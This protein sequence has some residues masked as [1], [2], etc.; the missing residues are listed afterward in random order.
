[1]GVCVFLNT[2]SLC[3][4]LIWIYFEEGEK[5][6]TILLSRS[7]SLSYFHLKNLFLSITCET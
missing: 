3:Q 7:D 5:K 6:T 1:M 2:V 4:L